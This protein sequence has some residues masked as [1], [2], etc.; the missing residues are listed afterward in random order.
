[1]APEPLDQRVVDDARAGE[2]S[3]VERVLRHHQ[4]TMYALCRRVLGNDADAADATQE[5]MIAVVRGLPRFDGRSALSTWIYRVTTNAAL[6]EVRRRRRRPL[7]SD[8]VDRGAASGDGVDLADRG[9][10]ALDDTVA[11]RLRL[12]AALDSLSPEFRTAVVLRDV[13]GLDYAEIAA[14]LDLAPGTVRSRISRGRSALAQ[15]LDPRPDPTPARNLP[16]ADDVTPS[17][18]P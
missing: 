18:A 15:A 8:D 12:D 14:V 2:G 1:V 6:D 10:P 16:A 17:D 11:D 3:A 13:I 5:A 9:G 7:I 4:P